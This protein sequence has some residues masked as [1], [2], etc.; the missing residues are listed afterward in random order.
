[1]VESIG[2]GCERAGGEMTFELPI[3]K[4]VPEPL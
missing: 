4:S 2:P 3:V 1:V